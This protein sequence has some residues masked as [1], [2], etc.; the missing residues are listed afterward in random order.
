[1]RISILDRFLPATLTL[2]LLAVMAL[3]TGCNGSSSGGGNDNEDVGGQDGGDGGSGGGDEDDQ[4]DDDSGT[5]SGLDSRPQNTTCLAPANPGSDST[6]ELAAAFPDLPALAFPLGLFQAPGDSANLYVI[7][8]AGQVQRFSHDPT[9][10]NVTTVLDISSQVDDLSSEGGLLG[11]AFHPQFAS[12]RTLYL[13]YTTNSPNRSVISRFTM[14]PGG[15]I[16]PASEQVILELAQPAGNHNGGD[17]AFGPE[18]GY[19][20]IGFGDGGGSAQRE[21][22]QDNSNYYGAILRIDVNP[23]ASSAPFYQIPA[24]NPFTGSNTEA[25]EI[26]AYGLRNPFRWSFDQGTGLLWAGDVGQSTREEIDLIEAGGN[27]GWPFTEG[28]ICGPGNSGCEPTDYLQPVFDYPRSEG[29]SITGGY[30]YRS[31]AVPGLDGAY[32]YG[33]FGSGNVWM[34]VND[35]ESYSN[36]LIE[37]VS[38]SGRIVSFGQDQSGEVYVLLAFASAG[39]NILRLEAT[40]TASEGAIAETLSATGCVDATNPQQPSAAMIP[41]DVVAPLWSDGADK[42]RYIALPDD[43]LITLDSNGDFVFPVGSVLMKHFISGSTYI[44]T[45]LLMHHASGWAGY[46][47]EWNDAQT[48]ADLLVGSKDRTVAGLDWHFPSGSECRQCHT[49]AKHTTLGLEAVQLNKI[50]TYP[51]TGRSANQLDTFEAIALFDTEITP[52]MLEP[53]LAALDDETVSLER[54]AK[55]YLHSNCSHCHLPAGTG[56]GNMDMRL[57]T[58]LAEMNLCGVDAID[59]LGISGAQRLAPGNPDASVV[60]LRMERLDEYRMPP[61]AS[62]VV[63]ADATVLIRDWIAGVSACP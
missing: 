17:I 26:Y 4:D 48:D 52:A 61:L 3:A 34:L 33:D 21:E 27:Y 14:L 29:T 13:S 22:A 49:L 36:S 50:F 25:Q 43:E 32:I 31:S 37:N 23:M 59:D 5:S 39:N 16:D 55:S 57:A 2:L 44:E 1:M 12:N 11:L 18:D 6:I 38:G 19:L 45:R 7:L 60:L 47:Y 10:N 15:M 56:G 8:R 24:D 35:G 54:R 58:P 46:S 42:E 53:P 41:Y 40:T 62:S 51:T 30:V 9:A 63:D 28:F 20:Y